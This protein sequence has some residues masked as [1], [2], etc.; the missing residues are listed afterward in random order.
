MNLDAI[1]QESSDTIA[2]AI[3]EQLFDRQ[4][5]FDGQTYY[6]LQDLELIGD[7]D[8]VKGLNILARVVD[9]PGIWSGNLLFLGLGLDKYYN[10][11][12]INNTT[13]TYDLFVTREAF[14]RAG[15]S[16]KIISGGGIFDL[17]SLFIG[18]GAYAVGEAIAASAAAAMATGRFLD[19]AYGGAM[20]TL[21]S[22]TT[23]M[24]AD[25][26]TGSD[27]DDALRPFYSALDF[28]SDNIHGGGGN[29]TIIGSL[30]VDLIDGGSGFDTTDFTDELISSVGADVSLES[31][32]GDVRF[33]AAVD[34]GSDGKSFLFEIEALQLG[35]ADDIVRMDNVF[36]SNLDRIDGGQ[37][38][39]NT[40][41]TL[42]FSSTPYALNLSLLEGAVFLDGDRAIDVLNFENAIGTKSDDIIS[43]DDAIEGNKIDGRGGKDEINGFGGDDYLRGGNGWDK[44]EGGEG[45]D[46]IEA[47][48]GG[49]RSFGDDGN[50]LI[51]TNQYGKEKWYSGEDKVWGGAGNDIIVGDDGV[52]IIKGQG[53]HDVLIGGLGADVLEG[54][55]GNDYIITSGADQVWG[56]TG[57]D[58]I[59]AT[60]EDSD[61]IIFFDADSGHDH[62]QKGTG[63][64]GVREIV[65]DGLS[66]DDVRMMWDVDARV[67]STSRAGQV[68]E[69]TGDAYIEVLSTGA[70][71]NIGGVTGRIEDTY[72]WFPVEDPDGP[73]ED[74]EV[75]ASEFYAALDDD[76]SLVFGNGRTDSVLLDFGF[77][78]P[79]NEYDDGFFMRTGFATT[80]GDEEDPGLV[81]PQRFDNKFSSSFVDDTFLFQNG[82]TDLASILSEDT[83][84]MLTDDVFALA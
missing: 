62:I 58:W 8:A 46:I 67:V 24:L 22:L 57:R 66:T 77:T 55:W 79:M 70:T 73:D 29:D 25:F 14:V 18:Q 30:G 31:V 28:D 65:F 23:F 33:S 80:R 68:I 39:E 6:E 1:L 76:T 50:D 36:S 51:F 13:S 53:G 20:T 27:H 84:T 59:N 72:R 40:G 7:T 11:N 3:F 17:S 9:D 64:T 42:D 45:D 49:D 48:N 41:D 34:F 56:G 63:G 74:V 21:G 82:S 71:I 2:I 78:S 10:A 69:W 35:E 61:A 81:N 16:E 60:A 83:I 26:W 32:G 15:F 52:D 19:D 54:Q 43:G 38:Q 75:V 12:V 37:G 5:T 4:K 44:V 47:G